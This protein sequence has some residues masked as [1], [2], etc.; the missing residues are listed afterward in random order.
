MG[1]NKLKKWADISTFRH[2]I[3]PTFEEVF[4]KNYHLRGQWKDSFFENRNPLVVELGCGKGEYTVN[5]ARR[6]PGKN[7]IGIDIKGAR[8]WKGAR[9]AESDNL[10]NV[11]FIRTRI[12]FI[13]SFFDQD[14]VDEIWITF[15]DPQ[16]K[17][18]RIKKRLTGSLFLN[19]YKT[20]L[21]PEGV[22]HLKTDSEELY[23]YTA[24]LIES[25]NL[26]L[27]KSDPDIHS[28]T[29][30]DDILS[31][32]THYENIFLKEGK[33]I[34]YTA[35]RIHNGKEIIEPEQDGEE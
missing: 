1:K 8:L 11:A 32:I 25:N 35:F 31:I 34:T 28:G 5:L 24:K 17:R 14:E 7:F 6:Y 22:I 13:R 2:V 10:P 27:V 33:K 23:R 18:Q 26:E 12:E 19:N 20:F 16:I 21:R 29:D 9:E 15:P 30:K 3:Q 4:K